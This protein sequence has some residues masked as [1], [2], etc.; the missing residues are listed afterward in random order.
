MP[1]FLTCGDRTASE[2]GKAQSIRKT[3][4][5]YS[6]Q[7]AEQGAAQTAVGGSRVDVG[8]TWPPQQTYLALSL[9]R[10]EA[11]YRAGLFASAAR[12]ELESLRYFVKRK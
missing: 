7:D 10:W 4:N 1:C 12:L 3:W 9:D 8:P 5:A 2:R 6:L 11:A